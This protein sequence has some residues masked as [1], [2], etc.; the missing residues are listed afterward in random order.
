M[1]WACD[2]LYVRCRR[3]S[4]L[5]FACDATWYGSQCAG[6]SLVIASWGLTCVNV[7]VSGG[8]GV[9]YKGKDIDRG[10]GKE[11]LI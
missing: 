2:R 11:G 1:S 10:I 4:S 3:I 7:I 5:L 8:D 9:L 6:V